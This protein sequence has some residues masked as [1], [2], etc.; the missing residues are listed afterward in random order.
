MER[1]AT[2]FLSAKCCSNG[3][4]IYLFI[5]TPAALVVVVVLREG[6]AGRQEWW[7]VQE[8]DIRFDT[9]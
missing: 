4:G 7:T 3:A 5:L 9:L 2:T 1:P 8:T 6:L